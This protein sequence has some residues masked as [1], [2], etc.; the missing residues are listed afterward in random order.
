MSIKSFLQAIQQ[1]LGILKTAI[2]DHFGD[3]CRRLKQ[4]LKG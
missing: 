4:G 2:H 3:Y 1:K